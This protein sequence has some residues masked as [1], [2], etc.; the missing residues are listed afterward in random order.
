MKKWT[1][2]L[3]CCIL[4]TGCASHNQVI[5]TQVSD[6]HLDDNTQPESVQITSGQCLYDDNNFSVTT[7]CID[8]DTDDTYIILTIN[9]DSDS[10]LSVICENA[11]LNNFIISSDFS[12]EIGAHSSVTTGIPFSNTL[13]NACE[14][15]QLSDISFILG[16]YDLNDY[17]YLFDTGWLEIQTN[18]SVSAG[19]N[20]NLN[21]TIVYDKNDIK[22]I[23]KG[24][25][26]DNEYNHSPIFLVINESD[27]NISLNLKDGTITINGN[28]FECSYNYSIPKHKNAI[29]AISASENLEESG[30][31][32]SVSLTL[33][34]TDTDSWQIIDNTDNITLKTNN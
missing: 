28:D 21:G 16:I 8:S 9:N 11:S 27:K 17:N 34:L 29:C 5:E 19:Q 31:I 1:L 32:S 12:L 30:S 4:L 7:D 22:I 20:V 2:L 13:L 24:F 15:K 33:A 14:I 3:I 26:S 6:F 10:D 25:Y 18:L 23:S